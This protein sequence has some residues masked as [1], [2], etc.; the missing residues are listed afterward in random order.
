MA[1]QKKPDIAIRFLDPVLKQRW[2][3]FL[4]KRQAARD[5]SGNRCLNEA[6]RE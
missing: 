4:E 3:R 1:G 5:K 2:K 6:L